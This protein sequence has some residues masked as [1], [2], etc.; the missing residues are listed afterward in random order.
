MQGLMHTLTI[1][2]VQVVAVTDV[3]LVTSSLIPADRT[4]IHIEFH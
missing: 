1:G 4:T 2:V 3:L